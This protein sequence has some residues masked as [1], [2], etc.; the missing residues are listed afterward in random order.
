[1]L[2]VVPN[3]PPPPPT[4]EKPRSLRTVRGNKQKSVI[5]MCFESKWCGY[6]SIVLL[7]VLAKSQICENKDSVKTDRSN[8]SKNMHRF[9][10]EESITK[11]FAIALG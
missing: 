2:D 5:Q 1:M 3:D 11:I 6:I 4:K 9:D 8:V 7:C 10:Q